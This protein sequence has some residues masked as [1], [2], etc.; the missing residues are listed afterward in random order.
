MLQLITLR[1]GNHRSNEL[2]YS[3]EESKGSE[4]EVQMPSEIRTE[5]SSCIG[6][7]GS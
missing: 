2:Y 3:G 5:S 4:E 6:S 7:T 1:T